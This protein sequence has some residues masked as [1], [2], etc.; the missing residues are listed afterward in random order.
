MALRKW[1]VLRTTNAGTVVGVGIYHHHAT[2]PVL[3]L[4]V[5][6]PAWRAG[7]ACGYGLP[8]TSH[9]RVSESACERAPHTVT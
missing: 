2:V 8:Y 6:C 9:V 5:A 4:A 1:T 3:I 7:E